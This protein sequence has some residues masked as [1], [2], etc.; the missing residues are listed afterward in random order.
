MKCQLTGNNDQNYNA[1]RRKNFTL[2]YFAPGSELSLSWKTLSYSN[3]KDLDY[4]YL[5][6][7]R[8]SWNDQSNSISLKILYNLD[9]NSI[10]RNQK[11]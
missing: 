6:N 3:C 5:S 7:L 8:K 4:N 10:F 2:D 1:L 9:V 11:T